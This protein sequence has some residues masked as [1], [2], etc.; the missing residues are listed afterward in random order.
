M[1]I[2]TYECKKCKRSF[3]VLQRI[4]DDKLVKHSD[5]TEGHQG[6]PDVCDGDIVRL[7]S[8]SVSISFKGKGWTKRFFK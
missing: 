1:P 2:Y 7:I 8:I 3:D 4:T 5:C 6:L